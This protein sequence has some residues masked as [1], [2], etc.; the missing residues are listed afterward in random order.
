[1]YSAASDGTD[2]HSCRLWAYEGT[3]M[4]TPVVAGASAMIRQYFVDAKFYAA[5]VTSRGFC[6]DGFL[7]EGFSPSSATVKVI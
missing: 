4:S 6:D 1:I 2:D 5:D 3:S 7:C